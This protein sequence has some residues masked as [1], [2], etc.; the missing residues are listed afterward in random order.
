MA[1]HDALDR[2]R[3]AT[4]KTARVMIVLGIGTF[5]L[6]L[7]MMAL[8][9]FEIDSEAQDMGTAALVALYGFGGLFVV[10]GVLMAYMGLFKMAA[11]GQRLIAVLVSEPA[12]L[13]RLE[14]KTVQAQGAPGELGKAHQLLF[15][16]DGKAIALQVKR[17][18]V[19][20]ILT[21]VGA[22]AP[23]ALASG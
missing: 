16:V 10:V 21:Y 19:Q 11:K 2:I 20:P 15:H 12:R 7:F 4:T 6:G 13:T 9:L 5:L 17:D 18:D 1:E 8:H 3:A 23:H 14:Y 22:Q